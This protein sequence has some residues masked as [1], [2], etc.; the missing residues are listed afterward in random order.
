MKNVAFS[1][2][3]LLNILFKKEIITKT[4]YIEE[5][6]RLRKKD[7]DKRHQYENISDNEIK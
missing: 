3:A 6:D 7:W 5:V 2:C 1:H 4:E